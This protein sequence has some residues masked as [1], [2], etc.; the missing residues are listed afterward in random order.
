MLLFQKVV[1]PEYKIPIY[2]KKLP[3][4]LLVNGDQL[5]L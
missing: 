4:I 2:D 5:D 1:K 3:V